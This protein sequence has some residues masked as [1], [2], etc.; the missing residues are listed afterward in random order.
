MRILAV[1]LVCA[2]NRSEPPPAG[3]PS[4]ASLVADNAVRTEMVQLECVLE[5]VVRAIGRDN[6]AAVTPMIEALDRTKQATERALETGTYKLAQG[7]LAGF[8]AMDEAF[9]HSL[10]GLVEASS[11]NDHATTATALG[12]VLVQCQTCHAT[13][14]KTAPAR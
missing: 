12:A 7:D 10:V 2:C 9:H 6:L 11:K 8:R 14:R 5:R 1:V 3:E 4:C 13:F